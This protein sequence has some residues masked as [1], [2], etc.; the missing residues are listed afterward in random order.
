MGRNVFMQLGHRK[1]M[2]TLG[3]SSNSYNRCATSSIG[4]VWDYG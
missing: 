4:S 1:Y 3:S 2:W